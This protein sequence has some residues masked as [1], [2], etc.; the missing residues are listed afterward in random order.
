[1]NQRASHHSAIKICLNTGNE[2]RYFPKLT[3][4]FGLNV[5]FDGL[6]YIGIL[7]KIITV[8]K[9]QLILIKSLSFTI[10]VPKETDI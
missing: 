9:L 10:Y 7:K 3:N 2:I 6:N 8:K 1:M 4:S 5:N